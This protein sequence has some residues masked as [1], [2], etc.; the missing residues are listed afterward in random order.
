MIIVNIVVAT[1]Q[2]DQC[3][4]FDI[5]KKVGRPINV[6]SRPLEALKAIALTNCYKRITVI[7]SGKISQ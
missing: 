3:C 7:L 6:N 2:F 5:C 4:A 1:F